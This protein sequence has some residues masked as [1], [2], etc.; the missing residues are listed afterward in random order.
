MVHKGRPR[1]QRLTGAIEGQALGGGGSSAK[2][3][4]IEDRENAEPDGTTQKK[5]CR[6]CGLCRKEGHNR[7]RCPYLTL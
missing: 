4:R 5:A 1:T 2:K 3:R 6:R 7:A